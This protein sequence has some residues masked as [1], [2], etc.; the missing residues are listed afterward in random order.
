MDTKVSSEAERKSVIEMQQP[1]K[2]VT[3][4][5]QYENGLIRGVIQMVTEQGH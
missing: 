1:N 5:P 4:P 2:K 3:P